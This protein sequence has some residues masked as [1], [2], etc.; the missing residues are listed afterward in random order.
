MKGS[1]VVLVAMWVAVGAIVWKYGVDAAG[2]M[3]FLAMLSTCVL[4]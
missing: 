4:V 1:V 2:W 3:V